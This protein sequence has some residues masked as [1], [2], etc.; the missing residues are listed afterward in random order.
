MLRSAEVHGPRRSKPVTYPVVAASGAITTRSNDESRMNAPPAARPPGARPPQRRVSRERYLARRIGVV[1]VL[2][3]GLFGLVKAAGALMGGDDRA[4]A[5][6]PEATASETAA[7]AAP[8]ADSTASATSSTVS[9]VATTVA[10][11]TTVAD[12]GPPSADNPAR[13]LVMGDSDAGTFGPYLESLMDDT[14]MVDSEVDYKVSSGLSR[15]DFFDWPAHA[16]AKL[17]EVDPDIVVVTF[18]G[19]DA[20][21]MAT[22]DGEF[23][24]EWADPVGGRKTWYPE[25]KRRAG[26]FADLLAGDERTIIWVGIPNDNNPEVT[27][28]LEVQDQAVRAALEERPDVIFVDTWRRFSGRDG[29]WA[30]YVIDPRDGKGKDVRAEDGFHLNENGAE[31]LALDIA[32]V[33]RADLEDRGADL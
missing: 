23:P 25:Y 1:A 15:P 26:E 20:Q 18:G 33:I 21:G 7:V 30:E 12:T 19:N 13:L 32:N 4:V 24:T 22:L 14:G 17:E 2:A 31:I 29:N 3:L 28:R 10:P 27:K 6:G 9:A 5:E 16:T 8:A 11:A